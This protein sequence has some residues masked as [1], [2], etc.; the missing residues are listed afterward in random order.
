MCSFVAK[1]AFGLATKDHKELKG[2][3]CDPC[4]LLWLRKTLPFATKDRRPSPR[5]WPGRQG[6]QREFPCDLCVA[7][8]AALGT[9]VAKPSFRLATKERKE[10][11]ENDPEI[12]VLFRGQNSVQI[13]HV[14]S[15]GL[16]TSLRLA[17]KEP[18]ENFPMIY[19]IFCGKNISNWTFAHFATVATFA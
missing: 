19:V 11:K 1:P 3:L 14:G 4:D 6:S 13:G 5:L 12:Y 17:G 2:L 9:L 16:R 18:K 10:L 7:D 8:V 15:P